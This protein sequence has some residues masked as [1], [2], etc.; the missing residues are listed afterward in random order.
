NVGSSLYLLNQEDVV[1][2]NFVQLAYTD[3]IGLLL[4]ADKIFEFSVLFLPILT[5]ASQNDV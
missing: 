1:E 3:A 4:R 5:I 2:K